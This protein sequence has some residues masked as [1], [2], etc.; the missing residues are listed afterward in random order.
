MRF[1][2]ILCSFVFLGPFDT[3]PRQADL[4]LVGVDAQDLHLDLLA[5]L[6][7]VLGILDLVVGQLARCAASPSRPSS[8][9]TKTPKLVIFVTVPLTIWPGWYLP[10]MSVAQ[11]SSVQLLQAQ[12]D[13]PPLLI[14]RKHLALELSALSRPFRSD[15]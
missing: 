5:D 11:G 15:G 10:G 12:G 7:D 4:P 3:L 9:P 14:D 1:L 8:R 6:D 13:A 2:T